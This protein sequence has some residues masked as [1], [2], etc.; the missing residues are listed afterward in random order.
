DAP[1]PAITVLSAEF[2]GRCESADRGRFRVAWTSA[3]GS[4]AT[5]ARDGGEP[6]PVALSG[7]GTR[8]AAA[9][10]ALTVR[11]QGP[12][13]PAGRAVRAGVPSDGAPE[14]G[15]P[16]PAE[17]GSGRPTDEPG[18]SREPD[19]SR[20]PDPTHDPSTPPG[21]GPPGGEPGGGSGP[22]DP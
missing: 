6:T 18:S 16:D 3:H 9:G 5:L 19:G 1:G 4:T 21:S 8:C 7:A 12:G 22:P 17:P 13:G 11:V 15:D 20:E 10:A 2:T 14:R